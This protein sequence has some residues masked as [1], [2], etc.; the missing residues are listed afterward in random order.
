M[1]VESMYLIIPGDL[2]KIEPNRYYCLV[3]DYDDGEGYRVCGVV[4]GQYAID[5]PFKIAEL[6]LKLTALQHNTDSD[7]EDLVNGL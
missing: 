4:V 2:D 6:G 3:K 5:N 1:T 7:V